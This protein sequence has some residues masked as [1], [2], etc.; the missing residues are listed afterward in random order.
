VIDEKRRLEMLRDLSAG[1]VN[2]NSMTGFL[3]TY[4]HS[5]KEKPF[6]VVSLLA[7]FLIPIAALAWWYYS[8]V[9]S[10]S[11]V[12]PMQTANDASGAE[13]TPE[14][15]SSLESP[16]QISSSSSENIDVNI[17]NDSSNTSVEV[18]GQP[19]K[20]P[21]EGSSHQ[22]IEDK[23]GKTTVDI[24]VDSNTSGTN[25]TRSS[26]NINLRSSSNSDVHINSKEV[27]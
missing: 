14:S 15:Q 19:V 13:L 20:V 24:Q 4:L 26:T 9:M 25:R 10:V 12:L 18:D 3:A 17:K 5:L 21:E 16:S 1:N 22:V 23:D 7:I 6:R 8:V 11:A 2:A 27:D